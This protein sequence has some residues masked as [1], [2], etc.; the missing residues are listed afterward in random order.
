MDKE[1]QKILGLNTDHKCSVKR[2][3]DN[4]NCPEKG[5]HKIGNEYLCERCYVSYV[6]R[7]GMRDK[8]GSKPYKFDVYKGPEFPEI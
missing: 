3:F 6:E 8:I 1:I 2:D 7:F 4:K 5:V